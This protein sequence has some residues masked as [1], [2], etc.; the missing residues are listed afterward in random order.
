MLRLNDSTLRLPHA[1][2]MILLG[3]SW[4]VISLSFS[5]DGTLLASADVY[6]SVRIWDVVQGSQ[7]ALIPVDVVSG[8]A[9]CVA[10]LCGWS[11]SQVAL[12][13][14]DVAS[15][16][17]E[18]PSVQYVKACSCWTLA[19]GHPAPIDSIVNKCSQG[20]QCYTAALS[21]DGRVLAAGWN[22]NIMI[23]NW[24]TGEEV[25]SGMMGAGGVP[26]SG[27]GRKGPSL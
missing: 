17:G 27:D 13:P 14:E 24:M 6:S 2:L 7:V 11:G 26:P 23:W 12:I 3:H 10:W 1:Q 18:W 15:G 25:G 8:V 5:A 4:T 21:P 22:D 9:L 16:L 19:W 20:V